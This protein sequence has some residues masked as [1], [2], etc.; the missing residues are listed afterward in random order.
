LSRGSRQ[1]ENRRKRLYFQRTV[2]MKQPQTIT[3]PKKYLSLSDYAG[4]EQY[5]RTGKVFF[6]HTSCLHRT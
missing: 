5:Q 1:G 6:I 2:E 4:P 3:E